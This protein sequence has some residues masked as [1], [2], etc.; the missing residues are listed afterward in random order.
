MRRKLF[1]ASLLSTGLL[2][3][4]GLKPPARAQADDV[5]RFKITNPGQALYKLAVPKLLGDGESAQVLQDVLSGDLNASGLF[6]TLDPASFVADLAKEELSIAPDSWRTV[7]AEG[8]VKARSSTIGGDLSIEFRLYEVIKGD[9]P[10]LTKTY[11]APAANVRRLAHIF[12]DEIV[13]YYTGEDSFFGTQIAFSRPIGRQQALVIMD[14][15]GAGQRTVTSN[16]SQNILP[17]WHP[18]GSNLLYTSFVRGSPDLWAVATSGSKPR[19]VSTKPGLNTGGVF[20]PD[21]TKIAVTL[22]FEGNSEIYVVTPAGDVIKRLTSNPAIDSSPTWSPDGSQ[23]AF[24]SDR[25]GSPQIWKMSATGADQTKLTR[26]GSYNVEP[27]WSPKLL[28]GKS[29]IAFSGRDEKGNLDIF[30]VD[31]ASQDLQRIT[32]NQGSN[33]H[34]TWAPTG[35]ALAF[36]SSRG[37]IY[38]STADG[39][40]QRPV[41]RGAAETPS[42]GPHLKP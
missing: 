14:Y 21:G 28:N 1:A 33:S 4:T 2:L 34:P 10:V 24:V 11:R 20:S 42:W 13:R 26:R 41:F 23:I 9:R 27:A 3:A 40:T 18:S 19:R 29:L 36:K 31:A 6:K 39:K 38:V 17:S 37:G 32:E 25:H 12:A 8:V 15:D 5:V 7:G 16:D 30:T 22:S 35:R